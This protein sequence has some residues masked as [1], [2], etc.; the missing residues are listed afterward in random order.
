VNLS[1]CGCGA[2]PKSQTEQLLERRLYPATVVNPK[3]AATFRVLELFE[4][5]QYE[6]KLSTYEFYQ[7]IS[8]L[9]D[10]TGLREPK[11]CTW[12]LSPD[13]MAQFVFQ[14]RYPTLLRLVHQW[15]HLKLL[16]RTGRGHDPVRGALET[17]PGECALLCP[18]CPHPGINLPVGW[19]D[20]PRELK[21]VVFHSLIGLP[22]QMYWLDTFM[23]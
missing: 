18:A 5:L 20:T 6:S 21:Y 22:I 4:L 9:T 16:K 17:R 7:T 13:Q 19:E 12:S 15:R 10:N 8:R 1:Y 3:T 2:T 23:L 11:V 14:D